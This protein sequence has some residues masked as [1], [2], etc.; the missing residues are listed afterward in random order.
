M[1]N[2]EKTYIASLGLATPPF[3]VEQTLT[4]EILEA[5]AGH[6]LSERSLSVMRKLFAHPS[7]NSRCFAFEDSET[8]FKESLDSRI[9]RFTRWSIALSSEAVIKALDPSTSLRSFV[10]PE[11]AEK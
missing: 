9:G 6:E 10:T 8:V 7:I 1:I 5:N 2:R 3:N 4:G 11:D